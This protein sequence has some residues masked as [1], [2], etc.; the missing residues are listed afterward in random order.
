MPGMPMKS[1]AMQQPR[2][3]NSGVMGPPRVQ[4]RPGGFN[5]PMATP[6]ATGPVGMS[7]GSPSAPNRPQ[8]SRGGGFNSL[9]GRSAG[10]QRYSGNPSR[11]GQLGLAPSF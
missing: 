11:G 6:K 5:S 9:F 4:P 3:T 10:G 7:G 2:P 1:L 8:Q